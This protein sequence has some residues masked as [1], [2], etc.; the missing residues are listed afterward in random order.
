MVCA[1]HI[2]AELHQ[3]VPE[4]G[5]LVLGHG[6]IDPDT[7]NLSVLMEYLEILTR[8]TRQL[9]VCSFSPV[10]NLFLFGKFVRIFSLVQINEVSDIFGPLL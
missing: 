6:L 9:K 7:H 2:H 8:G 10:N 1:E 5:T 3:L 4:L